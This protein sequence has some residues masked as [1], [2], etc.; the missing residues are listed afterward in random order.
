[1]NSTKILFSSITPDNAAAI[2]HVITEAS[3][4]MYLNCG[5]T[6]QDFDI[7]FKNSLTKDGI[8]KCEMVLASLSE[9]EH[10]IVAKHRDQIIGVCYLEESP[11]NNILHALYILPEFQGQGLGVALWNEI[12]R[13]FDYSKDI[14]LDVFSCN[15]QAINFYRKLGFEL[16]G[17]SSN[18][19]GLEEVRMVLKAK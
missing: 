5:Y 3:R 7:K 2:Q 16:S 12:K 1:M 9:K 17:K 14:I 18:E 6:E 8:R 11:S 13:F 15:I 4:A 19:G 10:Y